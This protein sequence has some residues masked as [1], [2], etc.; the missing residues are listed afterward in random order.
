[1]RRRRSRELEANETRKLEAARADARRHSSRCSEK[2]IGNSRPERQPIAGGIRCLGCCV[3][4]VVNVVLLKVWMV[5]KVERF[6]DNLQVDAFVEL[7]RARHTEV[8]NFLAWPAE[9]VKGLVRNDGKIDRWGVKYGCIRPSAGEGH[10]GGEG[11]ILKRTPGGRPRAVQHEAVRLVQ[12]RGATF[13]LLIE[14]IEV[15]G[16]LVDGFR[17]GVR[18][19][20]RKLWSGVAPRQK[21]GVIDGLAGV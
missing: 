2:R 14:L 21:Q 17:E 12:L 8:D 5:E 6:R 7:E 9:P 18:Q 4:N 11:E 19:A 16:A 15:A 20:A 10:H 1:M 3:L 13:A